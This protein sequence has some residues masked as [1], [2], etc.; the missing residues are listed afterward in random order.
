MELFLHALL[1]TG[2]FC[3]ALLIYAFIVDI[4]NLD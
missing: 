1:A 2:A 4:D 3:V